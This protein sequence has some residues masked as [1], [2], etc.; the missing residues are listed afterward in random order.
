MEHGRVHKS[1]ERCPKGFASQPARLCGTFYFVFALFPF[2]LAKKIGYGIFN[3]E[4]NP[5]KLP[6]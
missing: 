4:N 6:F 2:S 5:K 3:L 1:L